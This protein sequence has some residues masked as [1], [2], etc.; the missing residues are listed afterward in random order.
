MCFFGRSK[1][2]KASPAG[3]SKSVR[4]RTLDGAAAM[5]ITSESY[6]LMDLAVTDEMPIVRD[7]VSY[8]SVA[9]PDVVESQTGADDGDER[10]VEPPVRGRQPA[11]QLA[12]A[13]DARRGA[14]VERRSG[15]HFGGGA[16]V[17]LDD[18]VRVGARPR[19]DGVVAA[20]GD[21]AEE[22][23]EGRGESLE[24]GLHEEVRG[25]S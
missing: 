25:L 1:I 16:G 20:R 8:P 5:S 9:S 18:G 21:E 22:E 23:R 10:P 7:F 14:V 4:K 19:R 12:D 11:S 6:A 17:F 13:C 3:D 15:V 24:R 2:T